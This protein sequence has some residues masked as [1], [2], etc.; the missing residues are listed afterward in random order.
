MPAAVAAAIIA[1]V[2]ADVV[3]KTEVPFGL[4]VIAYLALEEPVWLMLSY[5]CAGVC[6]DFYSVSYARRACGSG[7]FFVVALLLLL[8]LLA[9]VLLLR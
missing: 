9:A 4:I 3:A 2:I 1:V 6:I 8:L 7:S 5:V